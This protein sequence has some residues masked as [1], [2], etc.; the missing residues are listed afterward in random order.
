VDALATAIVRL[1]GPLH[2]G[3]APVQRART[4]P[5]PG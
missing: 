4:G 2:E 1:I 5:N 3:S